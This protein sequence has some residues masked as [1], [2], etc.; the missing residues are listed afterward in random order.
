M[1]CEICHQTEAE[2]V[3]RETV[4]GEV[5]ERFVCQACAHR[6]AEPSEDS[7]AS[8][9]MVEILLGAA[10]SLADGPDRNT[11]AER[12]NPC[13]ACGMTRQ[14]YRKRSRLGCAGC[15]DHFARELQPVLRD[16]HRGDR[17]A[18]KVPD[19]ARHAIARQRLETALAE[20]VGH[21]QFEQAARLRDQ[22]RALES[23]PDAPA[24]GVRGK[25]A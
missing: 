5:C 24:A 21:Q 3:I 8:A 18:G 7:S 4:D 17:H 20:A 16:M 25:H 12:E 19:R 9:L 23:A 11:R 10:F 14:E 6:G 2:T 15:Y 1:K 13:P 22:I